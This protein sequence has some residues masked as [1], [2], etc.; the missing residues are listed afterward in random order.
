MN[1]KT[2]P[3]AATAGF[4]HRGWFFFLPLVVLAASGFAY[5]EEPPS[6]SVNYYIEHAFS[7][8]P[9][10]SAMS[11]RI[12]AKEYAAVR[13]GALDDPKGWIAVVNL[14]ARTWSFR[15]EDMTGKEIGFSQ[16]FPYPGKRKLRTD[17]V[18][19]QKEEIEF[20]LQEMRNMLRS[21]IKMTYAELS[22]VRRQADVVRR[23]REILNEIVAVS[24]EMY[25]VGKVPQADVHRGQVE[26]EKMREMLLVLENR[27]KVLSIRLNTLAALPPDEPVPRLPDLREFTFPFRKDDLTAIYMAGRPARQALQARIL[28]GE[29]SIE[30]AKKDYYP[31]FEVSASYMQRDP[32]PDGTRRADMITGMASV[33][34]P[35]WRREKL[36]PAV[37]EMTAEREMARRE[38][39]TLDLE[40]SNAIGNALASME[41]RSSVAA[42]FRTTLIPHAETAFE[43]TLEAY[44]VGKVDFPTLMDS[45]TNLLSFRKDYQ[46]T[47]GELYVQKARLEAAV[48]KELN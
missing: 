32:M 26:F 14:P 16:M 9:S 28:Q 29:V 1:E 4:K 42:L 37:R 7:D 38:L 17:V 21:E 47:V 19:K 3:A 12:R 34:L 8:N 31:D 13:A 2:N 11:E 44:R 36:D 45:I 33:T 35:I 20:D 39:A 24:E 43:T 25:A 22:S 15:E 27:E 6:S 5:A 30:L 40:A 46:E 10:L 48:G 41:N 18:L 23:V